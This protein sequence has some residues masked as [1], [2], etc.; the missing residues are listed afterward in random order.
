MNR[1]SARDSRQPWDGGG[2][3]GGD[4]DGGSD[5]D[6]LVVVEAAERW[7]LLKKV[8]ELPLVLCERDGDGTYNDRDKDGRTWVSGA[9][10]RVQLLR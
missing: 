8:R 10:A 2:G 3:G 1:W 6:E 7:R 5:G 4:V 9:S